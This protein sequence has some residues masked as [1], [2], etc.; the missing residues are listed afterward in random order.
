MNALHG[1]WRK[2]IE[3]PGSATLNVGN[4]D[5]PYSPYGANAS[6]SSIS[7]AKAGSCAAGGFYTD[8]SGKTHAFVTTR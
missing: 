3:A 5:D 8:G 4:G 1:V 2:A 7:C 6:V